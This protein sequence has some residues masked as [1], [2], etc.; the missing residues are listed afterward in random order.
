MAGAC[1]VIITVG[2]DV[3]VMEDHDHARSLVAAALEDD[4]DH[5]LKASWVVFAKEGLFMAIANKMEASLLIA[6]VLGLLRECS[7][8]VY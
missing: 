5:I 2:A 6:G 1:G 4:M 7:G 3:E 8:G